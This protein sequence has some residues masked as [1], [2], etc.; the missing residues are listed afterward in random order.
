MV[1]NGLLLFLSSHKRT[2]CVCAYYFISPL[3]SLLTV[4]LMPSVCAHWFIAALLSVRTILLIPYN[5][6]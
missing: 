6:A 5:Y 2:F 4:S 1:F 3:V